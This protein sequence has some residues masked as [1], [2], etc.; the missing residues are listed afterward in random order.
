LVVV[1]DDCF[2]LIRHPLIAGLA[3]YTSDRH[4]VA[5]ILEINQPKI[6]ILTR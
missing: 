4:Y 3:E 2:K 6:G 1:L 5:Y